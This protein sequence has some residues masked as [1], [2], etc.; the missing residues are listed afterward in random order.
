LNALPDIDGAGSTLI[1]VNRR[2]ART[3]AAAF[4][5]ARL[6]AGETVW[7]SLDI[8]PL[9]S[10][11]ART[12]GDYVDGAG[13]RHPAL[14]G[15][16]QDL[17]LWEQVIAEHA[18]GAEGLALL[19]AGAAARN[20]QAAW[21]TLRA[22]R[23]HPRDELGFLGEDARVFR[24]W[25]EDYEQRCRDGGWLDLASAGEHLASH[26]HDL[27]DM[28][29]EQILLAGFDA[30]TPQTQAIMD[31]LSERGVRVQRWWPSPRSGEARRV[32]FANEDEEIRGAAC[33]ARRR[34]EEGCTGP[35]GIVVPAL[36]ARRD[37]VEAIFHEVFTPG[38]ARPGGAAHADAFN[39]SLGR[40][41]ST[42]PLAEDALLCLQAMFGRVSLR[43]A[44]RWLLSPYLAGGNLS[45]RARLDAALRRIGEPRWTL[46]R[47][48][49][50]AAPL[51]D[52]P[53]ATA[54]GSEGEPAP[55]RAFAAVLEDLQRHLAALPRRQSV[56][57]WAMA[58][59]AWLTDAGWPGERALDSTEYQAVR[60]FRDTLS[61]LAGLSPVLP[62]LTLG[63][64]LARLHRVTARQVFQAQSGPTTVQVLGVLEA[65]GLGYS[66]LW[67]V[68]LHAGA[69]PEPARP[70]PFLPLAL[71]RDRQMPR[72]GA[73]QQLAWSRR[74]T[75]RM[76][77]SADQVVVSYPLSAGDEPHR[78][79]PLIA[80]LPPVD[81]DALVRGAVVTDTRHVQG[82]APALERFRDAR[83]PA[84]DRQQR[85]GGGAQLI[86]DQAACPFRAF[87]IHRLGARD[88]KTP[89]SSLDPRVR[90]NLAHR[91]LELL[92]RSLGSHQ[93]LASRSE[94]HRHELIAECVARVLE[95]EARQ[96][97]QTL[98]GRLL[99]LERRR[100]ESLA[101]AWLAIEVERA[102]FT[103]Q[104]EQ[105][106]EATLE[107]L[108]LRL[109]PDRIDRLAD[110]QAF[111]V[112]YKTG[113]C[114]VREWFGERPD[115]P[116]LPLYA[117]TMD[118]GIADGGPAVAGIAFGALRPGDL[119]FRGL[120]GVAGLAPGVQSMDESRVHGVREAEDWDALK[121]TWH[122]RLGRLAR[123][124]LQ[125]DA[126]VD[127]KRP[128]VTC[129]HCGMQVLCRVHEQLPGVS[130]S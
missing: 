104:A 120:A 75:A 33:W 31:G 26:V 21:A 95:D 115:E 53:S 20:A 49:E 44:G 6:A 16:E 66:N 35:V 30:L 124:Y 64:A 96:R 45:R 72:A 119:G 89:E 5:G 80:H 32:G 77:A 46:A 28:V 1:T 34:V 81:G 63:E 126:R 107:G 114:N 13:G 86:K 117:V 58:F 2:L 59:S 24:A 18:A 15:P 112:D 47:L 74:W 3:L 62:S 25:A 68:G 50:L 11:L 121:A 57:T 110:G 88:V 102:P 97:P 129:R 52:M 82:A 29:S 48:H 123:D 113:Q 85:T 105:G 125:G 91:L 39:I 55:H 9:Q 98:R 78:P 70:N 116:Q 87:A 61:V 90:G 118:V 43:D 8:L 130:E 79:S 7:E 17:A 128:G 109:R 27:G 76:L 71:Q 106:G 41:L 42:V 37:R 73:E 14:L 51:E 100:L 12:W 69:W 40:P 84:V 19:Q 10:W 36:A 56:A 101:R 38:S 122:Q 94:A 92:W 127:P 67:I 93:G 111:L 60:A 4:H 23:L 103:V 65:A 22:W 83:G 54:G 108:T 99:S